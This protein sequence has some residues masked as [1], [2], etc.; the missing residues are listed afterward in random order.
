MKNILNTIWS[1]VLLMVLL[2]SCRENAFGTVD[3]TLPEEPET[4]PY[5]YN[6]PSL[7]YSQA[8][9]DRVKQ[10]LDEGTAPAPVKQEFENLKNNKY[11]QLSYIPN[12]Q[13]L[14]VRGDPTGTG[15]DYQNYTHAMRDAAAA[16]QMAL[17]WKLTANEDYAKKSIEIM[18]GWADV[19]KKITSNDA[20]HVLAA[21]CQGYTFAN[22]AEIMRDYRGWNSGDF[23]DFKQWMLDV[24]APVNKK[25]L[26]HQDSNNCAEHYWSNW[27]LVNMCSYFAIGVL[28]ENDEMVNYVVDYFYNGVGNGCITKLI[29]GTHTDP[30]GTGETICQNQESGRDQGHAQMSTAVTG[31]LCQMAYTL[32]VQNPSDT[33]LDFYAANDN[34]ILAMA[35]YVALCNLRNGTD[36]ANKSGSWLVSITNMPFTPFDYCMDCSCKGAGDKNLGGGRHGFHMATFADDEGRGQIRPVWETILMHYSK[37]KKL[38]SGYKYLSAFAEKLRP[39]GGAGDVDRYGDNSGAFDQL[40]W[41]T[42]MMYRE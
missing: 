40:G 39:E 3:L 30:L 19:C 21:G 35:E 32:F 17:L 7:M 41:S 26:D 22:A 33:R 25:F 37:V 20:D 31:S 36:S 14:I 28:A 5:V 38:S 24:F 15:V 34:A 18:N 2:S 10:M 13:E 12:P 1:A 42:L 29:R 6:H 8:D 4:T 27:D 23:Q 16:Y 9:F 11:T